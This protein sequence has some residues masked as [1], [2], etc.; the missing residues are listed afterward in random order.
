MKHSDPALVLMDIQI[1]EI[2]GLEVIRR[3]RA[4]PNLVNLPIIALTALAMPGD[5]EQCLQAGANEYLTKP[6]GLKQLLQTIRQYLVED[7]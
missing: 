7:N 6:V 5:R 2:D 3:V 1:P 4:H